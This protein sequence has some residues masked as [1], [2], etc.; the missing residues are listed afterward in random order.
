MK[1]ILTLLLLS[2]IIIACQDVIELDLNNSAPRLV[3][4][5]ELELNEDGT[6][7][8]QVILIRSS[9]FYQEEIVFVSD[10]TVIVTDQAGVNH[11]FSLISVGLY[12][13]TTLNIQDG[14]SYTLTIIDGVDTYSATQDFISTVPYNR[15]EQ[16]KLAGFSDD[17][18]EI[19]GFFNDPANEENYY[20]FEFID[21]NNL[22]NQEIDIIGDEFSNGNESQTTFFLDEEDLPAGSDITLV[23]RGIDRRCFTFYDTLLQQTDGGGGGPFNAQPAT[24]RGNVINTTNPEKFP[25][26]YFRVSQKF[27]IDYTVISI[28]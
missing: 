28:P 16:A 5:A 8:A 2:I 24:V 1:K 26:G 18:T 21:N 17:I 7:T 23:I 25:F 10:A 6:T 20:L 14:M 11:D 22:K 3:I 15:V 13:N 19:T 12:T 27:E 4:D 9:P